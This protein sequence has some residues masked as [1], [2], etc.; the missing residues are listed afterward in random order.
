[1]NVA[2]LILPRGRDRIF[3]IDD[4]R[5]AGQMCQLGKCAFIKSR[6]VK[7]GATG[8]EGLLCHGPFLAQWIFRRKMGNEAQGPC[9]CPMKLFPSTSTKQTKGDD[10]ASYDI[11][12]IGGAIMGASA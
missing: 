1:E 4:H 12:I 3:Q 8:T 9:G 10:M 11:V 7:D 5:I 2:C 6:H